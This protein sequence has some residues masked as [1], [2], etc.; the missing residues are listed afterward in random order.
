MFKQ[1]QY[2]IVFVLI[3]QYAVA[4]QSFSR[5]DSLKLVLPQSGCKALEFGF[6][7]LFN[8]NSFMSQDLA[9][10]KFL[11]PYKARRYTFS[12]NING[13]SANREQDQRTYSNDTDSLIS[14]INIDGDEILNRSLIEIG[15]QN[16]NYTQPYG[17][18]SFCYGWGPLLEI[19]YYNNDDTSTEKRSPGTTTDETDSRYTLEL[20]T[21]ITYLVGVEWFLHKNISF[22]AE[23]NNSFKFGISHEERYIK[24][25]SSSSTGK[26]DIKENGT[27]FSING[28]A[29]VG[30]SFYFR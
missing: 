6:N 8:F 29:L 17:D 3:T 22:H 30:V 9:Y 4:F 21:G 2:V 16:I 15:F 14:E 18:L 25:I 12:F 28:R 26:T 13:K 11:T 20:L 1:F 5:N 27:L 10:K 19:D 7:G 23:Y 24:R